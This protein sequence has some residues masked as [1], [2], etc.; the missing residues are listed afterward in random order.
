MTFSPRWPDDLLV[1]FVPRKEP[2]PPPGV[3]IDASPALCA[4]INAEW[5]SHVLGALEVLAQDDTWI[6]T[7][8]ERYEAVQQIEQLMLNITLGVCPEPAMQPERIVIVDRKTANTSGGTFTAGSWQVRD[9]TQIL[10]D[11]TGLCTLG[12]NNFTPPAGR[13]AFRIHA[14]AS[15]SVAR[16]MARLAFHFSGPTWNPLQTGKSMSAVDSNDSIVLGEFTT[17]GTTL[18][19]VEHRCQTTVAGNGFGVAANFGVDETYTIVEL[20]K[21]RDYP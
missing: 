14:P 8:E 9:L 1:P 16:H 11:T 6:G 18:L 13:W 3:A 7:D 5:F 20:D 4:Q 21:L 15:Q 17:S 10:M 19:R 12:S 2:L